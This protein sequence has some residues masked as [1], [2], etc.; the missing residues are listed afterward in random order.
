MFTNGICRSYYFNEQSRN[1]RFQFVQPRPMRFLD[2]HGVEIPHCIEWDS[3]TG[4]ATTQEPD[5]TIRKKWFHPDQGRFIVDEQ[6]NPS[7]EHMKAIREKHTGKK[8]RDR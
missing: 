3:E 4:Y 5:G 2:R 6:H 1:K 7:E 8:E